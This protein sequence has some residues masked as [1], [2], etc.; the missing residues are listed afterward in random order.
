MKM[1]LAGKDV[2]A[3]AG[4]GLCPHT[5]E[6]TLP[7]S[8]EQASISGDPVINIQGLGVARGAVLPKPRSVFGKA[9]W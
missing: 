4:R 3:N 7:Q 1:S 8:A 2:C 5:L 6:G 9:A